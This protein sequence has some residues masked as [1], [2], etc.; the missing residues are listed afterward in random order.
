MK[1]SGGF[2]W[3]DSE[4]ALGT[5]FKIYF[6]EVQRKEVATSPEASQSDSAPA[7]GSETILVV[8]DEQA[9]REPSCEFLRQAGY[10]VL[11]ATNGREAVALMETH[12]GPI[13]LIVTD[14]VMPVMSGGELA[15]HCS[16]VR[17]E[18]KLLFVSGY[19]ESV[20]KDHRIL[21]LRGNFLQK[22]FGLRA[23][24]TKIREVLSPSPTHC[25]N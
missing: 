2:V 7:R 6:P 24:A 22:P 13:Q 5:R 1:Q 11:E 20:V 25:A 23:L 10:T 19:A 17:P 8:E 14:V 15:E 9:V 12:A 21:D 4:P 16:R 3:V 18:T